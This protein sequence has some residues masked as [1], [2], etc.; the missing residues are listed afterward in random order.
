[1]EKKKLL[2]SLIIILLIAGLFILT[3]CSNNEYEI[4]EIPIEDNTESIEEGKIYNKITLNDTQVQVE[5]FEGLLPEGWSANIDSDWNI[6]S[7]T[8]PGIEEVTITSPDEKASIVIDSQQAFVEN[9]QYSEGVNYDYYTTYLHYMDADTFVQYYIDQTY[10]TTASL[11]KDFE[12]DS[13]ILQKA[14]ECTQ[15]LVDYGNKNSSWINSGNYGVQYSVTAI[16][17]T[18]SK[19][20]Y[21][22]GEKYLEGSCVIMGS[23]SS[24]SSKYVATNNSRNWNVTYSIVFMAD[25]KETFDKYYDDY[26]FIIANSNFTTDYYAMVEYVGSAITNSYASYYAAKSQAG[27]DAMNNYTAALTPPLTFFAFME[28]I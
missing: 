14:N 1:M 20:Q 3:G 18:M 9:S 17:A 2:I 10:G 19:R 5:V 4:D 15:I 28:D 7:S 21:Q 13:E 8:C 22:V 23:D 16:P 25:D 24:L 27:L 26:N 6:V 11:I 12:D